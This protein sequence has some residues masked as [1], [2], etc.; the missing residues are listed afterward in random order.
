MCLFLLSF[1]TDSSTYLVTSQ[2]INSCKLEQRLKNSA[3]R[4]R[5]SILRFYGRRRSSRRN[6]I[7]YVGQE[8]FDVLRSSRI[9]Q[10]ANFRFFINK[11]CP[12]LQPPERVGEAIVIAPEVNNA[13]L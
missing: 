4:R 2:E 10:I 6:S 12:I 11:S 1:E 8:L 7:E 5:G 9:S 3:G 13:D